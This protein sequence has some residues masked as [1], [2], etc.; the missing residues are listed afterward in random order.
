[1]KVLQTDFDGNASDKI[2]GVNNPGRDL[3][4]IY[5]DEIQQA[6]PIGPNGTMV[7]VSRTGWNNQF[8]SQLKIRNIKADVSVH[9]RLAPTTELSYSIRYRIFDTD[10]GEQSWCFRNFAVTWNKLELKNENYFLRAYHV[11]D[12]DGNSYDGAFVAQ[13]MNPAWKNNLAWYDDYTNAYNGLING[14]THGNHQAARNY[15]DIGMPQ[16]G[17]EQFN[18]LFNEFKNIPIGQG[19]ARD[20]DESNLTKIMGQYN[21]R[22]IIPWV[23]LI[24]GFDLG[25]RKIYSEGTQEMDYP[26]PFSPIR[27]NNY[28]GYLQGKKYLLKEKLMLVVSIRADKYNQFNLNMTPRIA[29]SFE[30]NKNNF[31]RASLQTGTQNPDPFVSY[32]YSKDGNNAL[33]GGSQFTADANERAGS[34][35]ASAV[36]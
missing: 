10:F 33:V 22:K 6:I 15:A 26:P 25:W 1:M 5:G 11:K 35:F 12:H 21:F 17:S 28:S 23:Q 7:N 9:Y 14:V 32:G 34:S 24:A 27:D 19:G 4:N 2:R 3:A 8:L 30:L 31:L 20:I 18:K 36:N 16:P 13:L 29:A